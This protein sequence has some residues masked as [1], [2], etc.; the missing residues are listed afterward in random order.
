MLLCY[1]RRR[2]PSGLSGADHAS[3]AGGAGPFM[4]AAVAAGAGAA[5]GSLLA[6]PGTR[7]EEERTKILSICI[8]ACRQACVKGRG[9]L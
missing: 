5:M 4:T 6:P 2:L 1:A 7:R 9:L 8:H 3:L